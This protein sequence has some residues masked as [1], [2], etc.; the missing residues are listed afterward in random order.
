MDQAQAA[1]TLEQRRR[2][3]LGILAALE[4]QQAEVR[5]QPPP[6]LDWQE[7]LRQ[8]LEHWATRGALLAQ[9]AQLAQLG[10]SLSAEALPPDLHDMQQ[11][12][13]TL[14]T[15]MQR[16]QATLAALMPQLLRAESQLSSL[17]MQIDQI[18]QSCEHLRQDM[19]TLYEQTRGA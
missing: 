16:D 1:L 8:G 5:A 17:L 7:R 10:A 2:L 12:L 15:D 4:Q 9:M 14:H 6:L 11:D 19:L 13:A 3:L 18:T